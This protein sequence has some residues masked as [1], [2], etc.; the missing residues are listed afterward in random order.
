MKIAV[1]RRGRML[2]WFDAGAQN[3]EIGSN[4]SVRVLSLTSC[5]GGVAQ[6]QLQPK[7]A[8]ELRSLRNLAWNDSGDR[9]A[10]LIGEG[11][12]THIAVFKRRDC[13]Y[14]TACALIWDLSSR[15]TARKQYYDVA[16]SP[17]G[18]YV[19]ARSAGSIDVLDSVNGIWLYSF[20]TGNKDVITSANT[21][22]FSPDGSAL[23]ASFPV[24]PP[25]IRITDEV[26]LVQSACRHLSTQA[27]PT[28]S[29]GASADP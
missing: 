10:F 22:A 18:R 2:A 26:Q 3:G 9:L 16:V 24:A 12:M 25:L 21:L 20:D 7:S 11:E 13:S 23:A 17:D 4:V 27:R 19:A 5:L 14:S 28:S 1:N 8:P 15:I 29:C 6:L